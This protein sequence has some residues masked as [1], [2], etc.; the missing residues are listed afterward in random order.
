[1]KK[2]LAFLALSIAAVAAAIA[3]EDQRSHVYSAQKYEADNA[4]LD[5]YTPIE[6]VEGP[7]SDSN[8][9]PTC[10]TVNG[11]LYVTTQ[12]PPLPAIATESP[13]DA[14]PCLEALDAEAHE[15]SCGDLGG[16]GDDGGDEAGDDGGD[17]GGDTDAGDDAADDVRDAGDG[18]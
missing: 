1:M 10:I 5:T 18:G 14:S 3:C 11:A 9:T 7:T 13:A 8:C 16:G 4:C 15:A 2:T 12:C 6:V 17:E